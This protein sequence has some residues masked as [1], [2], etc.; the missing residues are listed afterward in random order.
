[1]RCEQI[2]L[3]INLTWASPLW[4]P[5]GTCIRSHRSITISWASQSKNCIT[6][7]NLQ[8][9]VW[10]H[11]LIYFFWHHDLHPNNWSLRKLK[12]HQRSDWLNDEKK[13]WKFHFTKVSNEN[14]KN[15]F[16]LKLTDS[17]IGSIGIRKIL[18][19]IL[20][21]TTIY[22]LYCIAYTKG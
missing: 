1:M 4:G 21:Y 6:L 16:N 11:S 7:Y 15:S 5:Y 2:F 8:E 14:S 9:P 18:R 22:N 13:K 3:A 12:H 19:K 20:R 10:S 17:Q